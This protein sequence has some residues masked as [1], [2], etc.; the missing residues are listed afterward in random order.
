MAYPAT[1]FISPEEYLEAERTAF[2]KHEYFRGEVV[3]MAGATERHNRIVANLIGEIHAFLKGKDCDVFPSDLRV[4]TPL[5]TS[6]MYPDVSIV[7]G[8]VEKHEGS[9]DTITNPSV[10]IEVMSPSTMERD[11]GFKF[12]Y[13]MQIPALKEYIL[14]D[15]NTYSVKSITRQKDGLFMFSNMDG[16]EGMLT[17]HSIGM[18]LPFRDIYYK[19]FSEA[20]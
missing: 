3:A 13:Y 6:Y 1:K 15:T 10:I 17:I 4:A 20:E 7:C 16:T 14:V 9:F 11:L 8:N 12:W 5:F 18:E 2:E 19:A